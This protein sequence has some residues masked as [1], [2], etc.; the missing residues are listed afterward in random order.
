M[1]KSSKNIYNSG[2]IEEK[3]AIFLNRFE[4]LELA[5]YEIGG[6]G[7]GAHIGKRVGEP[8]SVEL[9]EARED[10]Q[11]RDDKQHLARKSE[12]YRFSGFANRLEQRC[13]NNGESHD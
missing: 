6:A 10:E 7:I 2:L 1:C 9:P 4:F 8:C 13:R 5:D 3:W 12:E 11:Q